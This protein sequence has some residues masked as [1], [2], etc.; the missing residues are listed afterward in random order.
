M[1]KSTIKSGLN[2][3]LAG[4]AVVTVATFYH[5]QV[6]D[7]FYFPS[8]TEA[9]FVFFGFFWGGMFGFM[10]IIVTV[11]GFLRSPAAGREINLLPTIII[12]AAAT[13][14]FFSLFLSSFKN[15]EQPK[16]RPGETITI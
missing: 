3:L 4:V 14:L 16:V 11:V 15:N 12:L 5:E 8:D 7:L 9:Q 6:A 10:G 13:I 1:R 2:L